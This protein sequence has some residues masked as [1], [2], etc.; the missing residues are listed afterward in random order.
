LCRLKAT[1]ERDFYIEPGDPV[2]M[3]RAICALGVEMI[4]PACKLEPLTMRRVDV[5][6]EPLE[7]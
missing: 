4:N 6:M 2:G 3:L 5:K 7:K 1:K